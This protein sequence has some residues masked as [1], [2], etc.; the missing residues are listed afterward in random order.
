MSSNLDS[1]HLKLSY[2]IGNNSKNKQINKK[3]HEQNSFSNFIKK[4]P[5]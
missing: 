3:D 2:N 4:V 1:I 5:M